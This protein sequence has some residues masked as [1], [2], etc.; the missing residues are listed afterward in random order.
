MVEARIYFRKDDKHR[1]E[2]FVKIC[3]REGSSASKK[4]REFIQAYVQA[5]SH[6]NPQALLDGYVKG[7]PNPSTK[8]E[9]QGPELTCDLCNEWGLCVSIATPCSPEV[10]PRRQAGY[11]DYLESL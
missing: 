3:Q 7:R 1:W 9:G 6:G 10:C 4:L 5:H 2:E 8:V 11:K